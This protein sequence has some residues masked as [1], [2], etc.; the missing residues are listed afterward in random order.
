MGK[1]LLL[2]GVPRAG[3]TTL[4]KKVAQSLGNRAGG[5][6]TEEL[7]GPG[8]R[9]G[10][11]LITLDGKKVTLA[12]KDLRGP[13]IPQVGRYG[14][15]VS[16]LDRVGVGA[17]Q[18]ALVD[19]KIVIIDEIGKM[20]LLSPVFQTAVMQAIISPSTVLGTILAKPDPRADIFK[21]LA[22]VI[23]WSVEPRNRDELPRK[24]LEW[25]GD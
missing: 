19:G 4:I 23:Q 1:T 20:E 8:G 7:F 16:A 18:Q 9:K 22:N 15:D 2:T 25:L 24:I 11:A 17:I 3:K 12:H 13:N 6:Y 14:V 10:F 5:F 21:A